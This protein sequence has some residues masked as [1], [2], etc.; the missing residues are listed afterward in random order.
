MK[1][2]ISFSLWGDNPKYCIGAIKNAELAAEIYPDWICRFYCNK[3]VPTQILQNLIE[4]SNTE[5][6]IINQ[7]ADW[8]FATS[9]F[10]AISDYSCDYIIFRDTDSRLNL[11]EKHAV[12]E[13]TDSGK[14]LHIMKDHPGHAGFPILA[15][16]FGIK[17]KI[18]SNIDEVLNFHED[19]EHYHYDQKFLQ[20]YLYPQFIDDVHINDEIFNN[21]PFPTPRKCYEFV[22][23][24]FDEKDQNIHNEHTV[25]L[26]NFLNK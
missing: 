23:E 11:R 18:I 5:V 17:G 7:N 19:E 9:R 22:G 24:V 8:K 4:K 21:K 2:L 20:K 25:S 1:K 14:T 10:L 12:Q 3:N 13:W 15:G 26:V 16:M 6:F